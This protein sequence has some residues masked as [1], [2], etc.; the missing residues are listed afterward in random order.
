MK[1]IISKGFEGFCDRLQCLSDCLTISLKYNRVL[2]VDWTDRIWKEGFYRYF[3]FDGMPEPEAMNGEIWPQW[4][5]GALPKPAGDWIYKLKDEL[6]FEIDKADPYASVW[7]HPGIGVR[8]YNFGA[9]A[10]HWRLTDECKAFV[11]A[12]LGA[13]PD[14]PVVH[15]RGT[16]RKFDEERFKAL[17]EKVPKAVVVSDDERLVKRWMEASPDSVVMTKRFVT[18]TR[19][20][21]RVNEK[22]LPGGLT[23]HEMNLGLIADFMTLACAKEAHGLNEESLFYR[24]AVLFGKCNGPKQMGLTGGITRGPVSVTGRLDTV[25]IP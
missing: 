22:D 2:I 16:D 9:L 3:W 17:L 18:D 15:L 11:L 1:F 6:K 13:V 24:M 20:G 19:G 21:H 25:Q 5:D 10:R 23:K 14:L 8:T 4:W 7:V 12:Q